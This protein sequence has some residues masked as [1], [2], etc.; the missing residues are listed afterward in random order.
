M[1]G[2]CIMYWLGLTILLIPRQ[3]IAQ[4]PEIIRLRGLVL[5]ELQK[6]SV[7][8]TATI[9]QLN[10]L[11]HAFYGINSDSSFFYS[12][13][14]LEYAEKSNY[15]KG[16]SESWRLM[17]NAYKLTGDYTDMLSCYYQAMT[18]AEKIRDPTLVGKTNMNIAIFYEET[19]KYDEALALLE[20]AAGI[21][22]STGDSLQLA[23]V[24]SNI[25]D[26]WYLQQEYEKALDYDQQALQISQQLKNDYAIA[27]LNNDVGRMLAGKGLYQDA[28][29][30]HL[31]S[32]DYYRQTGDQLGKT[33]TTTYLA[34]DYLGLKDYGKALGYARQGLDLAMEIKGKKQIKQAGKVLA[35]IYE[36][37]G[38][39]RD[40][41]QYFKLYRDYSDSVFNEDT[42]K[43]TFELGARYEYERKSASLKEQDAKR[44]ILQQHVDHN[45]TLQIWIAILIILS[46]AVTAIFLFRS[47]RSNRKSNQLLQ[48]K[49]Q[50]IIRQ[51]EE[52]EHQA[53]QLLLN[54]QQKDKL[55]S[56][57]AHDL[58]GPLNS[59]KGMMDL[60]KEKALS[61][62][63]INVM[64]AE[65]RRNVDYSSELV[66]NLLFWASSQLNGI[67]VTPVNLPVRQLM[68]DLL[69][70]FVRQ[71][72]EKD[73][74]LKN[75]VPSGLTA[76]ADKDMMQVVVRNLLSNAVKFCRPGDTITIQGRRNGSC[77][78]VCVA[79]TGIGIKKEVL[80]K[81][82]RN[83]NIT[84]YGTAKEKGTGLGMLLCREFTEENKGRF[85]IESEWGKGSRFYFTIPVPAAASSSSINV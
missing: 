29:A 3:T 10:L 76:C 36:A 53:V 61:E 45:H 41:L 14:A 17:G 51:K 38:N 79:D 73:I 66:G 71:A 7:P 16:Q 1:K 28:L 56:I 70:L 74:T 46:L 37:K 25:S 22:R 15:A 13:K 75:E 18:I 81:I 19:G 55:F 83:E 26:T 48:A 80:D 8:D 35:D 9:D 40:A 69:V 32:M 33:E 72:E 44:D 57:I 52:I 11:A 12:K 34:G 42:R 23:Y 77:I 60:L 49:N 47:R 31:R 82:R 43:R 59:L 62:S 78:E 6:G 50:E 5:N 85:W 21:Y 4:S 63:E 64:M 68:N 27:F 39:Y 65:L 30:H 58:R 67:V 20:K 84:T 2:L 24:L 54:N